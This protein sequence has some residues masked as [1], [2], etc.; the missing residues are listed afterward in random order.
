MR[1]IVE[2]TLDEIGEENKNSKTH[3]RVGNCKPLRIRYRPSKSKYLFLVRCGEWYSSP[4]GHIVSVKFDYKPMIDRDI[5]TNPLRADARVFCSCLTADT[6]IPL[7]DGTEQT[8]AQLLEEYGTTGSFLVYSATPQGGMAFGLARCLGITRTTASLY[9][10]T[11][12]N[13]SVVRCTPDHRFLLRDMTYKRADTLEFGDRLFPTNKVVAAEAV[14]LGAPVPVYDLNVE[15]YEN[16]LLSAG[17]V[18][19]NCPAWQYWG[20]AYT[21]TTLDYNLE[22][23]ERRFPYIRDPN[24][25]NSACKHVLTIRAVVLKGMRL[26]QLWNKYKMKTVNHVKNDNDIRIGVTAEE[27]VGYEEFVVQ[28]MMPD[29]PLVSIGDCHQSV[30]SFLNH[31]KMPTGE[32]SRFLAD[33]DEDNF[34]DSLESVGMVLPE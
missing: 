11:L 23:D 29:F 27:P 4:Q 7:V 22:H 9:D 2:Y 24:L 14:T 28:E 16:F 3:Q 15:T 1:R 18:V 31:K 26:R 10:V 5:V 20:S 34:E 13:G 32:I 17:V 33:L 30:V 19:H 8:M 21:S 6:K 12:A 25:I